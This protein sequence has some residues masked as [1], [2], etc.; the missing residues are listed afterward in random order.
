MGGI[1]FY[2]KFVS[3]FSQLARPLHQ[4][5][6]QNNFIWNLDTFHH[7]DKL[8]KYLFFALV[9]RFP[10]LLQAFEIEMDASQ[11]FIGR[12]LKK[13]DHSMACHSD[14]LSDAKINYNTYDIEL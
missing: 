10:N 8:N 9:L 7:F 2:K 5:I 4:L 12:L 14:T 3:H 1:E 11:F 6:N 13:E